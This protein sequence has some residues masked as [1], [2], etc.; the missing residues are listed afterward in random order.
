MRP[1]SLGILQGN[2][3]Q[4]ES[5]IPLTSLTVR[6]EYGLSIYTL[7]MPWSRHYVVSDTSLVPAVD[8]QSRTIS[9]APIEAHATASF[10]GTTQNTNEIMRRDP[11]GDQ[12]HFN[13]FHKSIRP[14]LSPGS[15]L[16]A[17]LTGSFKVMESSLWRLSQET[18]KPV[19]LFHWVRHEILLATTTGEYGPANPFLDPKVE[20]SW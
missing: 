5:G 6:N 2:S 15:G 9:F 16:E 10:L 17:M 3:K 19:D 8:R 12:G 7:R 11:T 13:T 14:T 20:Q 4:N 18:P 1:T